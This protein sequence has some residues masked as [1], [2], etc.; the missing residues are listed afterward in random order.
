MDTEETPFETAEEEAYNRAIEELA[1]VKLDCATQLGKLQQE[2]TRLAS[3]LSGGATGDGGSAASSD[4]INSTSSDLI[5]STADS[6]KETLGAGNKTSLTS[7][8]SGLVNS[9]S[10]GGG[11]ACP[12]PPQPKECTPCRECP[13]C[14]ECPPVFTD[15]CGPSTTSGGDPDIPASILATPEAVLVGAAATLLVLLLAAAVGLVLRYMPVLISGL[16]ILVLVFVVWYLSSKYPGAARRLGARI[17]EALR[18]GVSAV[19]DRLLR[20]DRPDVSINCVS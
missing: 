11:S 16:S 17:W 20:R 6:G 7:V 1:K 13:S 3:G 8:I 19:V 18:S 14:L 9:T 2:V 4:L 10:S 5:N 15:D 12:D